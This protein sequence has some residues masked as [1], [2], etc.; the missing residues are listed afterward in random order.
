MS[1]LPHSL[2]KLE[3]N[4]QGEDRDL[5]R[6]VIQFRPSGIRVK[7]YSSIPALV[8]DDNHADPHPWTGASSLVPH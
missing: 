2:R 3:W 5:W 6:H 1:Q 4:C 7:R 8:S